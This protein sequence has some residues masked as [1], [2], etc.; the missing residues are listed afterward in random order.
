M[1]NQ[2]IKY[3]ILL[4]KE[5]LD[6]LKDDRQGFHR[7]TA[8]D[9]FVSIASTKPSVYRKTGFSA[10][11]SIGQFAISTVELSALWKCDRKTAAKV[12]ELFNQVGIL[13]T[14]RNNRTSIHTILCIAF[15]YVDGIK[16]A[17]KNPFYNRQAVTSATQE[18]PVSDVPSDTAYSSGGNLSNG[19]GQQKD[20][21]VNPDT[22]DIQQP[23]VPAS[24]NT[25][26]PSVNSCVIGDGLSVPSPIP[27]DFKQREEKGDT[28]FEYVV[29]L[30]SE[31]DYNQDEETSPVELL[32][33]PVYDDEGNLLQPPADESR[34]EENTEWHD[35]HNTPRHS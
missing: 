33:P 11:L 16:E 28:Y 20:I 26:S 4:T 15:W 30:P 31:N 2:S 18:K 14:E 27:Q 21:S 1:S 32:P 9:T 12:V 23:H 35:A 25:S 5:Q 7:M 17:I 19:T 24:Y 8:F 22:T 6:F 29:G 3:G 13:S 10:S 34:Y